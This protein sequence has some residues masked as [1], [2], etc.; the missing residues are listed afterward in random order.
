MQTQLTKSR[1][2]PLLDLSVVPS[3]L[4]LLSCLIFAGRGY[5]FLFFD[6]PVRAILWDESLL[7]TPLQ[8]LLGLDWQV[9]ATSASV[10]TIISIGVKCCALLMGLTSMICAFWPYF[11]HLRFTQ[12][13]VC[14]STSILLFLSICLFKEKNYDVLQVFELAVQ[15]V[16]PLAL[17]YYTKYG[18]KKKLLTAL[19]TA[20]AITFIAHGLFALGAWYV[21]GHFIDMTI[22]LL[23]FSEQQ[24]RFFLC[25]IGIA[26]ILAS[27]LIFTK[28]RL[29][30]VAFAYMIFWGIATAFARVFYSINPAVFWQS[31]H[32]SLYLTIYRLPHGLLPLAALIVHIFQPKLN[33]E[34]W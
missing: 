4:Y 30:Y 28:S 3:L 13:L 29:V 17:L 24:A 11:Y 20:I 10:A 19:K 8:S 6:V 18:Y 31:L 5:Q 32:S 14:T 25:C 1:W 16:T 12:T 26:D 15:I 2:Y 23:S 7:A 9:Y 21:P 34:S 33:N 27:I 22:K